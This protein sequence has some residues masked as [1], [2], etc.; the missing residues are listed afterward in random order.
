MKIG[1]FTPSGSGHLN[2]AL[3][4][5]RELTRRGHEVRLFCLPEAQQAAELSGCKFVALDS[6]RLPSGASAEARQILEGKSGP[7]AVFSIIKLLTDLTEQYLREVDQVLSEHIDLDGLL[8]DVVSPELYLVAE[9]YRL[10]YI[11][12]CRRKTGQIGQPDF[13]LHF[14]F[15]SVRLIMVSLV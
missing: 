9:K 2:P 12:L 14:W 4:L 5:A 10:P 13:S 1:L 8:I 11:T 3:A 15:A 7:A 6:A